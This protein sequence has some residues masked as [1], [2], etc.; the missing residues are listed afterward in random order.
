MAQARV[1]LVMAHADADT[2]DARF[3]EAALEAL[4]AL[5]VEV[6]RGGARSMA[7][8]AP[9]Q[10]PSP[11]Y[12]E[13]AYPGEDPWTGGALNG[14][15]VT[16]L[17]LRGAAALLDRSPNPSPQR[18]TAARL[19]GTWPT[20]ARPPWPATWTTT[21]RAP[22]ASAGCSRRAALA[23][24]P[25]RP[26][27][28]PGPDVEMPG[29][30]SSP[31]RRGDNGPEP[32]RRRLAPGGMWVRYDGEGRPPATDGPF[33]ETKD[34]HDR[35]A[36]GHGVRPGMPAVDEAAL[37]SL[38]PV[39]IGVLSGD[40]D[41]AAEAI[42]LT[43]G[44]HARTDGPEVAGLHALMLQPRSRVGEADGPRAGLAALSELDPALP[45]HTAV[46][47]HLREGTGD[48]ATAARLYAEA[49]AAATDLAERD[50]LTRQA[51]RIN[52]WPRG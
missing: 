27:H 10:E 15:M 17:N 14:F 1:A 37:P 40:V 11:W 22:G 4:A 9:G 50:H 38:V 33:A 13:R 48:L 16:L 35:T 2:G 41:V 43:R 42:R 25:G 26:E 30:A 47:A 29:S 19:R 28:R 51:A 23:H 44:L 52:A 12:L 5:T 7:T 36:H 46:D 24:L 31:R 39:V 45:R 3:A 6:D 34:L 8:T 20:G 18:A 49:A 21:T 32:R